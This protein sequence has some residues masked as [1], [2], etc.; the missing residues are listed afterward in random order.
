LPLIFTVLTI[1]NRIPDAEVRAAV[2]EDFS[3][4][5]IDTALVAHE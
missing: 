4:A 2:V 3:V 5:V 1:V